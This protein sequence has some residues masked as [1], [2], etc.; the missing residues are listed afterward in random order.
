MTD[1]LY[2]FRSTA[3]LLDGYHELENQEIYFSPPKDLNDPMEGF[4]NIL[5]RGDRILWANLLN[6][7]L[8]CFMHAVMVAYIGGFDHEFTE[9]DCLLH[10]ELSLPGPEWRKIF[11][12]ICEGFFQHQ[13][14]AGLPDLLSTRKSGVRRNELTFYLYILNHNA[15]NAVLATL[16]SHG[17]ISVPPA[18][19]EHW[20]P[21][22]YKQIFNDLETLELE[23]PE[24][25]DLGEAMSE[26]ANRLLTKKT[27]AAEYNMMV[28]YNS[29]IL[30]CPQAM[31]TITLGFPEFYVS[32]LEKLIYADWYAACFVGNHTHSAMWG[33]YGDGHRGVCLKF[34]TQANASGLPSIQL[35]QITGLQGNEGGINEYVPHQ[36]HEVRYQTNFVEIDFFRSLG[37]LN[38]SEWDYWY[39][40]SAGNISLSGKD[41]LDDLDSWRAKYWDDFSAMMTTKLPDWEQENEYRLTL[42][43]TIQSL[44]EI[45]SRRLKYRFEDLQG[46]IFGIKTSNS[47]KLDIMR[48]IESKCRA[49]GRTD[50]EFYQA[51]YSSQTNRIEAANLGPISSILPW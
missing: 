40:D 35:I 39:K 49:E 50:F 7:Y 32:Q 15:Y 36:F 18:L 29:T 44:A 2:R 12:E 13:D 33:H 25:T 3:A 51:Y 47:D 31:R 38:K 42:V 46:I 26:K 34:K 1:F 20:E 11:H 37:R 10:S 27:L 24:Q 14:V 48:I 23:H 5:W 43:M 6:H 17:L 41:V 8:L 45:S 21:I 30:K 9:N 19:I 22:G 28:E 16:Q 4:K